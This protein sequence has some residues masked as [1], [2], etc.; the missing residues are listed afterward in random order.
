MA[1]N[2]FIRKNSNLPLLKLKLINDGRLTYRTIYDR[3]ENAAITFSMMDD[4]GIYKVFNKQ[5][6]LIPV[7]KEICPEDGEYYLGYEFDLK[8]TNVAG[9]FKAE[10]KVDFLDN[11]E[12]LIV[13]IR[14]D[15]YVTVLDSFTKS[16][17][18]C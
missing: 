3:L 5:G 16:K 14:E 18:V 11:G 1:Q 4:K 13:P 12:S 7:D 8:D 17:I 6:L 2:F 10:F 9:V 15:L